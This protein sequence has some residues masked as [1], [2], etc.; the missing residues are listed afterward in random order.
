MPTRG[1]LKAGHH[2]GRGRCL[3]CASPEQARI[4]ADLVNGLPLLRLSKRYGINRESLRSHLANHVSPAMASVH[5]ERDPAQSA[6]L[7]KIEELIVEARRMYEAAKAVTNMPMALR[8]V[9]ELRALLELKVRISEQTGRAFRTKWA[10]RF[11]ANGPP[12]EGGQ[13]GSGVR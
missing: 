10:T 8:S 5:I 11:G 13:A 7:E 6:V 3:V 9:A 12:C 4:T 1:V 2:G